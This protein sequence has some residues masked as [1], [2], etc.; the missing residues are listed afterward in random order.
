MYDMRPNGKIDLFRS[1]EGYVENL[2]LSNKEHE[3][4][5]DYIT[6]FRS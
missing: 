5:S 4:T 3:L 2:I 1:F 6:D